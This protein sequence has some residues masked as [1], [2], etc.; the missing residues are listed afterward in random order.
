MTRDK[1]SVVAIVREADAER[2]VRECLDLLA[3]AGLDFSR[4]G[5]VLLK[6]NLALPV[7]H[8]VSPETTNPLVIGALVEELLRRGARSVVVGE[9]PVWGVK[10]ED[11]FRFT[12]VEDVV[13]QKGG[14]VTF[15]DA[16][17]REIVKVPGAVAVRTVSLPRSVLE[18]DTIINVPKMKTSFI[19]NLT[20]AIKNLL[21]CIPFEH[22]KLLHR[23]F[24]LAY[25][26]CDI[27]KVVKPALHIVD[28]SVA[29]EGYGPHAGDAV[30]S[31]LIVGGSDIVAVDAVCAA[32]MGC[33][34]MEPASTQIA[35]KQGLGCADLQCIRV[36]GR[37]IDAVKTYFARPVLSAV[38]PAP[39]VQ[40]YVGGVCP[41]CKPR[42]KAIPIEVEPDV[43]Y[44]CIF[45]REPLAIAEDVLNADEV[46]LV[47]NCGIRAGMGYLLSRRL[48]PGSAQRAKKDMKIVRVPGCPPLEWYAEATAFRH[49]R[50]KGWI[51]GHA[52]PLK[53]I[54]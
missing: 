44:A 47:G 24:D 23:E 48:M 39:N 53:P 31:D 14:E 13:R 37:S 22:R 9:A 18:A 36:V 32:I 46:W 35:A 20:L 5:R 43:K 52:A 25:L 19:M 42:V 15:F 38:H 2:A 29:M 45:G 50:D 8:S 16:E 4:M 21:G 1:Q 3:E 41:G 49:L 7:P 12:G 33:D 27:A 17:P 34:P 26:L 40:S 6:P 28:G 10:A 54:R 30:R 51:T 11:A